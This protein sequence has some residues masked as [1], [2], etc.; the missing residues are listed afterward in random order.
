M[1][2]LKGKRVAILVENRFEQVKLTEPRKALHEAGAT[3]RI[4]SPAGA[5]VK[6]WKH[7]EWGTS[8]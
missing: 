4:V 6:G 7:K 1:D 8:S 2:R 5:K 3:T